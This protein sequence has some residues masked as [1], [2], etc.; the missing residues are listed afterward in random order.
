[1]CHTVG[2]TDRATQIMIRRQDSTTHL[3]PFRFQ[4]P[5]IREFEFEKDENEMTPKR[6]KGGGS[7]LLSR[8]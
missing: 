7:H 5:E 8:I 1:M 2:Q 3:I 6:K 4:K